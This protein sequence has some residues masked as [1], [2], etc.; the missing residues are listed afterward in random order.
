MPTLPRGELHSSVWTCRSECPLTLQFLS[1]PPPSPCSL[2]SK[3]RE[4]WGGHQVCLGGSGGSCGSV[5]EPQI[6]FLQ[7]GFIGSISPYIL[8]E[9]LQNPAFLGNAIGKAETL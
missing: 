5:M 7:T 1:P 3:A 4:G 9:F 6:I 8:R 2:Q